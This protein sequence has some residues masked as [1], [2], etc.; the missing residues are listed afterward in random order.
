MKR[1]RVNGL[2]F[3]EE[4]K[5]EMLPFGERI[6]YLGLN[7]VLKPCNWGCNYCLEGSPGERTEKSENPLNLEE[8]EELIGQASELGIRGL[9][10]TGGEPL[11]TYRFEETLRLAGKAHEK[12]IVPLIYTNGSY[13]NFH[14][15]IA[16]SL[17]DVGA[18]VALKIDSL[19]PEKYDKIAGKKGAFYST[20]KAI[21]RIKATSIGEPVAE[22]EEEL[23]VRLLFTTVGTASNVDEYSGIARFA[24][25]NGARWM[26]EA[27]NL[28][29]DALNHRELEL[30]L[31]KHGESM[32]YALMLNPEQNHGI[33][34][35]GYCRLFYMVTVN[36][37]TGAIGVCPQDYNYL[38]NIRDLSLK[39]AADRI[40]YRVN[41][42]GFRVT[43]NTGKCPIKA[44]H[45]TGT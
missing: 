22:N 8:Q 5:G 23:L 43:W 37:S 42:R 7:G 25:I 44:G 40:L 1:F 6:I 16:D 10:I 20:R 29:G 4:L 17:S 32:K 18:S 33:D 30:D 24:T 15:E 31:E 41:D 19:I 12:G 34:A 9:L 26:M 35:Q 38:G 11:A 28:R 27:L 2:S 13:V 36:T 39:E 45:Y 21:E 3:E 14:P